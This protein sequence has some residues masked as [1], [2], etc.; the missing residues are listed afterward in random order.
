MGDHI[1]RYDRMPIPELAEQTEY[2]EAGNVR[3]GVEYRVVTDAVVQ[4]TRASLASAQGNVPGKL[5]ELDDCGVS[6]HVY[7]KAD[8][9][10]LEYLRFDCFQE[11]PHYHYVSWST[12]ENELLHIDPVADGDPLAWALDR[13]RTRL[14]QMF[15]RAQ[16]PQAAAMVDLNAIES[17]MPR[18]AEAAY[19]A[20]FHAD[21]AA[22]QK[23]AEHVNVGVRS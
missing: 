22:I 23:M 21:K 17:V 9:E 20:R 8:G 5:V 1:T 11:E 16:A 6:L 13:L 10:W 15:A 19:R 2:F 4:A 7:G 12:H 18:I 14:P 3:V